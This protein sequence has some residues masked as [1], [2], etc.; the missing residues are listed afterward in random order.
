[1]KIAKN[2]ESVIKAKIETVKNVDEDE[3][4]SQDHRE[5]RKLQSIM[6]SLLYSLVMNMSITLETSVG[7][8]HNE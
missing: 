6:V 7:N 3:G 2:G 4:L 8:I 5:Q 1:M